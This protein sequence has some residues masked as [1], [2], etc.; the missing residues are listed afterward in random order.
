MFE[1]FLLIFETNRTIANFRMHFVRY[2]TFFSAKEIENMQLY[3]QITQFDDLFLQKCFNFHER[4]L[5]H[6]QVAKI[7]LK[8]EFNICKESCCVCLQ[9]PLWLLQSSSDM[10]H[11][12]RMVLEEILWLSLKTSFII[13]RKRFSVMITA[14]QRKKRCN[15]RK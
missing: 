6:H 4:F 15:Q 9:V 13:L 7:K 2:G 3:S 11:C 14:E 12:K 1:I 5:F 10:I 8:F